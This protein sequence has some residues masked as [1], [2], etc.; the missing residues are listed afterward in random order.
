MAS[1]TSISYGQ[2][3]RN[4]CKKNNNKVDNSFITWINNIENIVMNNWNLHLLDIP[5][6]SRKRSRTKPVPD[7]DYMTYY[8]TGL[9]CQ[10]V[11]NYIK[12]NNGFS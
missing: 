10:Q 3:Y 12:N 5:F 8:V 7:E 11:V 6:S 2:Y 4:N 9:N 1:S